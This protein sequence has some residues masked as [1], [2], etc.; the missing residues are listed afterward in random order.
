MRGLRIEDCPPALRARVEEALRRQH[1]PQARSASPREPAHAV[2][3]P[4]PSGR[5][6][7]PRTLAPR[8]P[9]KTEADYNRRILAG[10]GLYEAIT[11][12]LP[13]GS[14]YTPDW[15]TF[16][17]AGAVTLHEIKGSYRLGSH[18]RALT[19]FREAAAAF[20]AFSFVWATRQKDGSYDIKRHSRYGGEH[21][22]APITPI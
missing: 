2:T 5:N 4:A 8:G 20:P 15:V 14:R 1:G 13:G 21:V 7:G 6:G 3:A 9:N 10:A 17:D 22:R 12:R 18:G 16:D 11:L 19:A